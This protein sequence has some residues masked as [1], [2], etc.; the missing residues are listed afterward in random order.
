MEPIRFE[1]APW[2]KEMPNLKCGI[3]G[4]G[5]TGSFAAFF[6][7]R[8]GIQKFSLI[9]NDRI[10]THNLGSQM[11]GFDSMNLPKVE[12]TYNML[13]NFSR[14]T[15]VDYSQCL[16]Q[17][18]QDYDTHHYLNFSQCNIVLSTV[19]SMSARKYVFEKF[20]KDNKMQ[21]AIFFDSRIGAELWEVYAVPFGDKEKYERYEATLFSDDKGNAGACNY[22]QSSHSA[23]GAAI[24][25]AEI[26]TQWTVN[27]MMEETK[28]VFKV[29]KNLRTNDYGISY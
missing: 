6:L 8:L 24:Q 19:D 18:L 14:V 21:H 1:G 5:A 29:T 25:I 2:Y 3:V 17:D 20:K 26:V 15:R 13:T 9:D 10:E 22:Q 11:F 16:I 4:L 27:K 28:L 7:A 12:A 23:A